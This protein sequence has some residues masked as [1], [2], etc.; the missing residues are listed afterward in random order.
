MKDKNILNHFNTGALL[1]TE[2][3][4]YLEKHLQLNYASQL[5]ILYSLIDTT[6]D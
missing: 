5:L 6:P 2:L 4:P 1:Q 3:E